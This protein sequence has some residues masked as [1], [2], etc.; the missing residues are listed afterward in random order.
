VGWPIALLLSLLRGRVE[1]LGDASIGAVAALLGT[2]ML[3]KD[4]WPGKSGWPFYPRWNPL[5]GWYGQATPVLLTLGGW[6]ILVN[7]L[8]QGR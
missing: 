2:L 6:L 1:P 3:A 4:W 7:A 8:V 5:K